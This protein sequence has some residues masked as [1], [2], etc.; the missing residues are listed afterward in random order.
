MKDDIDAVV[1]NF[2][3]PYA[4]SSALPTYLVSK[5]TKQHVKVALTGDGGDEVFGGYNKYHMAK[6]NSR[7]TKLIP[8]GV[9]NSFRCVI[10]KVLETK[11]DNRGIRFKLNRLMKAIN[12]KNDFYSKIIS[13]GFME[14][15]LALLLSC[16]YYI[17]DSLDYYNNGKANSLNDFRD[18]DRRISLEGDLLVKVDRTSML[19]SLECRAPFLNKELWNF[20]SQLPED[21]L[22]KGWNKKYIL[23][24]A[25][26]EYF[27]EKFLDKSKK[28][29]GIPVGDWLR[30]E[31]KHEL[32]SY[33]NPHLLEKQQIFNMEFITKSVMNHI[34]GIVDNTFRVWTF[35]CFQKWYVKQFNNL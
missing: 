5:M 4:D 19:N 20:T 11:D 24:E 9:H 26:K 14:E 17:K 34:N 12:Y 3:E 23:K 10:S 35:F 21:F 18:I 8:V 30:T 1:L 28:G 15:E 2:D 29:F 25:F 27:P 22:I 33:I 31:L 7:Y 13:L 32:L 6:F 16:D